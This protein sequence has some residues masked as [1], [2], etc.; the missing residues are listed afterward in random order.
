MLESEKNFNPQELEGNKRLIEV[1][2]FLVEPE[3]N[4]DSLI[5]ENRSRSTCSIDLNKDE[6]REAY[7]SSYSEFLIDGYNT[8]K[9]LIEKPED[10]RDDYDKENILYWETLKSK[11]AGKILI[12]LGAGEEKNDLR[13]LANELGA[14]TYVRVDAFNPWTG[15]GS[16]Y[17]TDTKKDLS[18]GEMIGE[19]QIVTIKD[20]MLD[21]LSRLPEDQR[22]CFVINGITEDIAAVPAYHRKLL[23]EIERVLSPGNIVFGKNSTVLRISHGLSFFK[24]LSPYSKRDEIFEKIVE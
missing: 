15:E 11:I 1:E 18:K 17:N 5:R 16:Q 13:N 7:F 3:S 2:N 10:T 8:Y 9:S 12:D 21:F 22:I 24:N 14:T 19:T 6:N 4:Y 20:D 23:H